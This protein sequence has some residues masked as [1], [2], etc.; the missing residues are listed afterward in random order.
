MDEESFRVG[1]WNLGGDGRGG[2]GGQGMLRVLPTTLYM[3]GPRTSL[4]YVRNTL[5]QGLRFSSIH[6]FH[7]FCVSLSV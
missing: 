5:L 2:G 6:K 3:E 1:K 7:I 4:D